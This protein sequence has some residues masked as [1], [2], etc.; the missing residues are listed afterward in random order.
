MLRNFRRILAILLLFVS[1]GMIIWAALPNSRQTDSQVLTPEMMQLPDHAQ[2]AIP[3]SIPARE[4]TLEWPA[5]MR[6]GEEEVITL[7]IF[8][9]Q[10]DRVNT[11]GQENYTD[12]Y[13]LYSLMAEGRFDVAGLKVDPANP[14]RESMPDGQ[15]LKFKWAVST[16]IVGSYDGT[17]WLSLRYLPLDGSQATQIPVYIQGINIQATSFFGMSENVVYLLGGLGVLVSAVLVYDDIISLLRNI[18]KKITP[19]GMMKTNDD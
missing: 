7:S 1:L 10:A 16:D 18:N 3:L 6:I 19:A 12:L 2:S 14:R 15:P 11:N 4:V 9:A 5:Q 13:S 8:P 17:V